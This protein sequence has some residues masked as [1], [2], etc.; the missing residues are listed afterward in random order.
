VTLASG[1]GP[2]VSV[3]VPVYETALNV[4]EALDSVLTQTYT[5]YEIIVV[6]DGS[7]DS[8]LLDDVLRPYR[9][10]ITYIVQ[11]NRG[12]SAARNSALKV[13]RGY[14]VAMLDSDDLWHPEYLASQVA[15]LESDATVD[16]VYPDAVRFT[17]E[18]MGTTR[19]SDLYPVGGDITFLRVLARKCQIYGE[20]T[21]RRKTLLSVGMYD[22]DLRS[23]EDYELWL[24]VLKAG[25]RIMYNDRVLAYYRIREGSHTSNPFTLAANVLKILDKVE[26]EMELTAEELASLHRERADVAAML[27]LSEGKHALLEGD[28]RTAISKL[29]IAADHTKSWKLGAMIAGLHLAPRIFVWFYRLRE[30]RGG[31]T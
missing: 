14:Y 20:V 13:A 15:L 6:N 2:R 7:P 11:E 17:S 8:E 27:S 24:R 16:V 19:Y 18:G 1:S 25:G 26:R 30:S 4:S 29:R 21:A 28:T 23:G 10:R 5:D 9:D 12:S 22:E 3:I 31:S